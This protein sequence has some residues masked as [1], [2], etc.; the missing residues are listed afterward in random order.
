M[1]KS[2][3]ILFVLI[4]AILLLGFFQFRSCSD[5]TVDILQVDKTVLA[6]KNDSLLSVVAEIFRR[7]ALLRQD[8]EL[9]TT[10]Y[11]FKID[12][13]TKREQNARIQSA[14]LE[15]ELEQ[16][17][18]DLKDAVM[19]SS[20]GSDTGLLRQMETLKKQ[21][22]DYVNQNEFGNQVNDETNTYYTGHIKYLDSVISEKDKTIDSLKVNY[23]AEADVVKKLMAD[24][25]QAIAQ[26]KKGKRTNI[27]RTIGEAV[28]V[29]LLI[30]KK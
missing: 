14:T 11:K 5:H 26:L 18:S 16:T 9:D 15:K 25:D 30:A 19:N 27:L 6:K 23:Y 28:L 17:I 2:N 20:S 12:S 1:I 13:L 22:S 4:A 29:I 21:F 8:Y 7:D 24:L 10:I 3:W